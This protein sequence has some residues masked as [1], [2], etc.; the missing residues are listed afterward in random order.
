MEAKIDY[1]KQSVSSQSHKFTSLFIGELGIFEDKIFGKERVIKSES[2]Y[3]DD[4]S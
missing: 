1:K 3:Q 2:F 4:L